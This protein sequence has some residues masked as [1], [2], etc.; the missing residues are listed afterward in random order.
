[1]TPIIWHFALLFPRLF[2]RYHSLG[3]W[4]FPDDIFKWIV[5]N[6]NIWIS[7]NIS[8]QLVPAYTWLTT[9]VAHTIL[10]AVVT[11]YHEN[12]TRVLWHP[13]SILLYANMITKERIKMRQTNSIVSY[14][15]LNL[16]NFPETH[17]WTNCTK[18]KWQRHHKQCVHGHVKSTATK[19]Q[20]SNIE[21]ESI[22]KIIEF[23]C[24]Y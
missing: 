13:L 22:M 19:F 21:C 23:H 18:T 2:P 7:I 24:I 14:L 12:N 15:L 4:K 16:T 10:R 11:W 20:C 9:S 8:L 1:M 6:E 5:L 3:C 17:L